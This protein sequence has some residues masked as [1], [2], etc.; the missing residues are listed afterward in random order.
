MVI[1]SVAESRASLS[2]GSKE[3]AVL[4][5]IAARMALNANAAS[6]IPRAAATE[7][8]RAFSSAEGRAVIDGA[9][10]RVVRLMD[11]SGPSDCAGVGDDGRLPGQLGHPCDP[12][13]F[14]PLQVLQAVGFAI[15]RPQRG[16]PPVFALDVARDLPA[17]S[18][19]QGRRKR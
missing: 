5:P 11:D 4:V 2:C 12:V 17:L 14:A 18:I 1:R 8:K 16:V 7:A 10:D 13:A 15:D 6:D 19:K 3:K 9:V